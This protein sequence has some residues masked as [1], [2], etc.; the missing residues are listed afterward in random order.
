MRVGADLI[1]S[2][3]TVPAAGGAGLPISVTDTTTNQ[4]GGAAPASTTKFYLSVD[5][6]WSA[7]TRPGRARGAGAR[8]GR[9][10]HGVH[11]P[12][13]PGRDAAGL[14][15]VV[16]RADADL[17]VPES[18]E[19]NNAI[20]RAIQLGAD[21]LFLDM[22]MPALAAAGDTITVTDTM[23]NGGSDPAEP[24]TTRY[25][26]SVDGFFDAGD[27]AIGSR[28]VPTL[29][30]GATHTGSAALTIPAGLAAGSYLVF[31]KADADGVVAETS[32]VNN[33]AV[34]GLQVGA[35]LVIN[36]LT[37]PATG[38]AGAAITIQDTTRN[39]AGAGSAASTTRFYLSLDSLWDAGDLALGSRAC[40]ARG[41]GELQGSLAITIPSG[42]A[43]GSYSV[44]ARADADGTVNETQEA[45]NT[46]FRAIQIG[47][48]LT[49][50]A[51]TGPANAGAGSPRSR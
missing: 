40:R 37:V 25:Y 24:S 17:V 1:V 16:A 45:N 19:A 10:E 44:F 26:L 27:P 28:A 20:G 34:R 11:D 4:G 49:M 35:D 47:P 21:L 13:D 3:C 41:G 51:L 39:Q 8:P 22:T 31:A 9:R 23:K 33:V 42:T 5:Y 43:T 30:P 50:S 38:G 12:D 18:E 7:T 15:Y 46:A 48:D 32:E 29:G 2:G 6:S 36:A 14:R